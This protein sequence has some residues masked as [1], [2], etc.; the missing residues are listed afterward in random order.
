MRKPETFGEDQW[1]QFVRDH[2]AMP[3]VFEYMKGLAIF[4]IEL[5]SITSK[6]KGY[7]FH[8]HLKTL[9]IRM[10]LSRISRLFSALM[11]LSFEEKHGNVVP[12]I[13]R[14]IAESTLVTRWIIEDSS[15]VKRLKQ[16]ICDGLRTDIILEDEILSN[17]NARGSTLVIEARMLESIKTSRTL[18]KLNI[19]D[20]KLSDKMPKLKQI[21]CE[22]LG[23]SDGMYTSVQRMGSQFIH[24]SWTDL[25]TFHAEIENDEL[26]DIN[27]DTHIGVDSRNI[28]LTGLLHCD[29]LM[30]FSRYISAD[31]VVQLELEQTIN[32]YK[33]ALIRAHHEV[34]GGGFEGV[35]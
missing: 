19:D 7:R 28:I 30:K 15:D 1:K 26:V 10:L 11:K 13:C 34:Y 23:Y 16:Y 2:N 18:A 31:N 8:S 25:L 32:E 14:C 21:M 17:V 5:A 27:Y 20:V 3:A 12:I 33:A 29:T 24:G 22:S 9:T 6:T 35:E 4:T